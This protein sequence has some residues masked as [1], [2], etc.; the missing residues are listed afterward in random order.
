MTPTTTITGSA[1]SFDITVGSNTGIVVGMHVSGTGIGYN[2]RVAEIAGTT[3]TL[4][5]ENEG[6]VSGNGDFFWQFQDSPTIAASTR[7]LAKVVSNVDV[8]TE[9]YIAYDTSLAAN[10]TNRTAS[11]VI[12][13]GQSVMVY[14]SSGTVNFAVNGFEDSTADFTPVLY[15]RERTV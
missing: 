9:D 6:A 5:V 11:T 4:N 3:I 10:A 13:P 1:A 2:A 14:S 15:Q 7:A 8:N 12:G